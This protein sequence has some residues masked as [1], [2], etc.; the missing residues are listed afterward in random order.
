MFFS[1]TLPQIQAQNRQQLVQVLQLR[2]RTLAAR[3]ANTRRIHKLEQER[4][5]L[6]SSLPD[7]ESA[8]PQVEFAIIARPRWKNGPHNQLNAHVK[9][10]HHVQ[11]NQQLARATQK[12]THLSK[13]FERLT[14]VSFAEY[15]ATRLTRTTSPPRSHIKCASSPWPSLSDLNGA[16]TCC[17][18]PDQNACV[19]PYLPRV[20]GRGRRYSSD[21]SPFAQRSM[22]TTEPYHFPRQNSAALASLRGVHVSETFLCPH[23]GN[24]CTP[25]ASEHTDNHNTIG[26][27]RAYSSD[28]SPYSHEWTSLTAMI[29]E[30]QQHSVAEG[31]VTRVLDNTFFRAINNEIQFIV[32][33]NAAHVLDFLMTTTI[34]SISEAI[35][36][37]HV[38][39]FQLQSLAI[40]PSAHCDLS[41]I[42]I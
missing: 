2:K 15:Q 38:S 13:T 8:P 41:L 26:L 25:L 9:K 31:P 7:T 12:E 32:P 20:I 18:A 29:V 4:I 11:S 6:A 37:T 36:A 16:I 21:P 22:C 14:A 34:G 5:R 10:S 40:L 24:L 3:I 27:G 23:A 19:R 30:E 17:H 42:H 28:P 35:C 33:Q 39:S 1:T